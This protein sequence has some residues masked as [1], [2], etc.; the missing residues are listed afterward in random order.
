MNYT[1]R[2]TNE[3]GATIRSV[4]IQSRDDREAARTASAAT[5][6]PYAALEIRLG[7]KVVWGGSSDRVRVWASSANLLDLAWQYD[8]LAEM[9]V[10][11][12]RH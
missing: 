10:K 3:I 2:Y 8:R 5:H 12:V 1:L 9:L 6:S 4:V 11:D 7:N